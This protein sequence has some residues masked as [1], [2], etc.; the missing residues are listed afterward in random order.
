[1]KKIIDYTEYEEILQRIRAKSRKARD[2]I[3]EEEV[4][5]LYRAL[6]KLGYEIPDARNKT[7]RD[8]RKD[9]GWAE[10]T[11][12]HYMPDEAKNRVAQENG[13]K[14]AEAQAEKRKDKPKHK[15]FTSYENLMEMREESLNSED[16]GIW[17][18]RNADYQ[19]LFAVPH[20]EKP[21]P[22]VSKPATPKSEA[23][24]K[25]AAPIKI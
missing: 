5:Q 12:M 21:E 8:L 9:P 15:L 18:W 4:P 10:D 25:I 19:F 16:R 22:K 7:M 2:E 14:A 3:A 6:K 1:L 23:E 20:K 13:R 17:E 11:I 24:A